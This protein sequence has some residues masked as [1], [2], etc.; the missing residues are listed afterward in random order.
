M[1]R[2]DAPSGFSF[3]ASLAIRLRP[4]WRRTDSMVRP[5]SY[6]RS[7]SIYG[8]TSGTDLILQTD[9]LKWMNWNDAAEDF[10]NQ[11]LAETPRPVRESTEV[12][13][14]GTAEALAEA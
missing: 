11:V 14:R 1:A 13:L 2:G 7:D 8:G 9:I 4:Y 10:L 12:Q 5:A 6:G 3:E